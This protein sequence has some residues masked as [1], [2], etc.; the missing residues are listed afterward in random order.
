MAPFAALAALALH[1]IG[2]LVLQRLRIQ[3]ARL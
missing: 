2:A 3:A 1:P